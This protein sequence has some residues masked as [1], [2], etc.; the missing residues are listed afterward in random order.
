L[1]CRTGKEKKCC[2]QVRRIIHLS[3]SKG[4]GV[5]RQDEQS[6]LWFVFWGI[7]LN[8]FWLAEVDLKL[9]L[10]KVFTPVDV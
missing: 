2:Q 6:I 7:K 1:G 10:A 8:K 3:G 4:G 9:K 5:Y